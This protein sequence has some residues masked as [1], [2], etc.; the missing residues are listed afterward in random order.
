MRKGEIACYKQFLLF[1]QCFPQYILIASK[2]CIVWY[3]WV[4]L[5][6]CS[7]NFPVF[8]CKNA[9]EEPESE[10]DEEEEATELDDSSKVESV[11]IGEDSDEEEMENE[12]EED[13][14]EEEGDDGEEEEEE[15]EDQG[16]SEEEGE[17]SDDEDSDEQNTTKDMEA[18]DISDEGK[19][20]HDCSSFKVSG[21]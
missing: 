19:L 15:A 11:E 2:C 16:N 4:K 17:D 1:S 13:S 21:P 9:G 12:D 14:E 10:D 20:S 7:S 8:N 5:C 18:V 3:K 6:M